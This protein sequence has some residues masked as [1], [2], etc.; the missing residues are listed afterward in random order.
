[1]HKVYYQPEGIWVGD[2]MPYGEDGTFY[3]YHQRD[4]RNP[5][6]FGEPFGWALATTKDFVNYK[7]FG[8]SLSAAATGSRPVHLCRHGV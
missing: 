4:T 2:I 7:D 8:E 1:M 5:E 6:P 3:L